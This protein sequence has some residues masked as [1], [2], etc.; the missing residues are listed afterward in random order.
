M[1]K[2]FTTNVNDTGHDHQYEQGHWRDLHRCVLSISTPKRSYMEPPCR[3]SYCEYASKQP[4]KHIYAIPFPPS[5][6]PCTRDPMAFTSANVIAGA[7]SLIVLLLL[8]SRYR[9]K[10]RLHPPPGPPGLPKIVVLDTLEA[11]R[12]LLD[13]RSALYS[14][15]SVVLAALESYIKHSRILVYS[16]LDHAYGRYEV[17]DAGG[18]TSFVTC[19]YARE[20]TC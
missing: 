8:V 18:G 3:V 5:P 13:R 12:E 10:L 14:D 20:L 11:A 6:T 15:R 17:V 19:N 2:V 7:F 4:I 9:S 1:E 16:M